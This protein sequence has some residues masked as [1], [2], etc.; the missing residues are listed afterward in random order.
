[1]TTGLSRIAEKAK[2][3]RKVR[4][5]SLAHLL[6]PELSGRPGRAPRRTPSLAPHRSGHAE[7]LHPALRVMDSLHVGGAGA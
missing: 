3:D 5:T 2:A 6:T 1:M 7:F 4:F